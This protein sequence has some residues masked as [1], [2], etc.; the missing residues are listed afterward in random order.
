MTRLIGHSSPALCSPW[1]YDIDDK[2]LAFKVKGHAETLSSSPNLRTLNPI[3]ATRYSSRLP[4]LSSL[5]VIG[6]RR[7]SP[8]FAIDSTLSQRHRE[9]KNKPLVLFPPRGRCYQVLSR[10]Y[11]SSALS[12]FVPTSISARSST[13]ASVISWQRPLLVSTP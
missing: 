13:P 10:Y 5:W 4:G 3:P 9:K 11:R 6:T 12:H 1:L 8:C 7:H 2:L